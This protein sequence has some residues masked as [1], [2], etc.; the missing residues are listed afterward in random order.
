[1]NTDAKSLNP[2]RILR[3]HLHARSTAMLASIEG[4]MSRI[5]LGWLLL[6]C[7]ACALRIAVSPWRGAG[8]DLTTVLPYMLV[9]GAPIMSMALA[10]R[11]FAGADRWG[12]PSLR[13]ARFGQWRDVGA[14]EARGH[15]LYGTTGLMVPL[16]VGMLINVPL[17]TAEYLAA[18]PALTGAVPDWLR[19]LNLLMTLDVVLLS[20][21]Y[22]VAFV[23][24]LRRLPSF[25]RLLAMVWIIDLSVQ[26]LIAG[27]A[28]LD[29]GLPVAVSTALDGLL[30][31]NV[32]KAVVSIA[33]WL[34]YLLLSTRVNVTFRHRIPA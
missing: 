9:I 27:V 25:P 22:V 8:P 3:Q 28:S 18:M 23:A 6:A 31:A 33:L 15:K 10:L 16:L 34:P 30:R 19:T 5:M 13:L 7:I 2:M 21:L 26:S 29:P 11:W 12:R 14:A 20:S 32:M 24:G 17:R 4:G 1:M